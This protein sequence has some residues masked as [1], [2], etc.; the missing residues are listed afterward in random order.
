MVL[1][2]CFIGKLGNWASHHNTEIY[3]LAMVEDLID[4]IRI[5]FL[6]D[7]VEGKN[8]Y[9]PLRLEQGDKSLHN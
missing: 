7:D 2:S 5:G 1:V 8:L 6:I 3:E 9:I 4:Y